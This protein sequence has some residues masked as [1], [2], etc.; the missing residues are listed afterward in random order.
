M[1]SCHW[2]KKK[3][4]KIK[5]KKKKE[6]ECPDLVAH[7]LILESWLV[8]NHFQLLVVE[9]GYPNGL[10]QSCIFAL[11]QFLRRKVMKNVS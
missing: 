9:V 3:G 10:N 4:L 7:R 8:Q 5:N 11:F 1:D 6:A 2:Y